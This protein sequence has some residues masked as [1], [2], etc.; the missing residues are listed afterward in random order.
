MDQLRPAGRGRYLT[1]EQYLNPEVIYR[2]NDLLYRI[3][4]G[5]KGLR[6]FRTAHNEEKYAF[7][8]P[9]F[10]SKSTRT[11]HWIAL[12][13]DMWN[14]QENTVYSD[15]TTPTQHLKDLASKL[16]EA[17]DTDKAKATWGKYLED[18][19]SV[20][21]R[22]ERVDALNRIVDNPNSDIDEAGHRA[23]LWAYSGY[24]QHVHKNLEGIL[25]RHLEGLS[26]SSGSQKMHPY[27]VGKLVRADDR[28]ETTF[29]WLKVE[30]DEQ[31]GTL[32]KWESLHRPELSRDSEDGVKGPATGSNV[33]EPTW[34]IARLFLNHLVMRP[35]SFGERLPKNPHVLVLGLF[36]E[37]IENVGY[38]G[39]KAT[40]SLLFEDADQRGAWLEQQLTPLH[41]VSAD[42][43][44]AITESA[45]ILAVADP[46][47]PPYDLLEH[48]LK[49]IRFVQDW[50][51][52]VVFRNGSF[53]YGFRRIRPSGGSNMWEWKR[54]EKR[55]DFCG[56]EQCEESEAI[57]GDPMG[58]RYIWWTAS[59]ANLWSKVFIPGLRVKE[60]A[61]FGACA[62]RFEFQKAARLPGSD[63][64]HA[65]PLR[66][67]YLRQQ[68][69]VMRR[70]V[71]VV[72]ARRNALR[73]AAVSI[74]A[75]N[76]SHNI[77]SHVLAAVRGDK[78]AS[79]EDCHR[80]TEHLQRRMDFIAE[81][82]TVE[83]LSASDNLLF[84][85][86]LG[87]PTRVDGGAA[88]DDTRGLNGQR[89]LLRHITGV[90][91]PHTGEPV[92]AIIDV[93]TD[94][95]GGVSEAK[96][97]FNS[98][99][100][101]WQA[102]YV[103]LE[104]I[105]RNVAKHGRK[106]E[107]A[108]RNPIDVRLKVL[109][110]HDSLFELRIWDTCGHA[111]ETTG[112]A[113]SPVVDYLS[114]TLNQPIFLDADNSVNTADWGMKEMYISAAFLRGIA[115]SDLEA[116]LTLGQE[117][118]IEPC[119][120]DDAGRMGSEVSSGKENLGFRIWL[121][122]AMSVAVFVDD[123][124]KFKIGE[125]LKKNG[126]RLF[127]V[128]EAN[129]DMARI[130]HRFGV[131]LSDTKVE[132]RRRPQLPVGL[133][134]V[135]SGGDACSYLKFIEEDNGPGLTQHVKEQVLRK[136]LDRFAGGNGEHELW[137][138]DAK[139]PLAGFCGKPLSL[140]KRGGFKEAM[141]FDWHGSGV[142]E[143][144]AGGTWAEEFGILGTLSPTQVI[145]E[146]R[147]YESYRSAFPQTGLFG[148]ELG[149]SPK[150]AAGKTPCAEP[151][152]AQKAAILEL[153]LRC[154]ALTPVLI[155]DE[156]F[157]RI[158]EQGP[159]GPIAGGAIPDPWRNHL[160]NFTMGKIWKRMQIIVP[161]AEDG[162]ETCDLESPM[163]ESLKT[164][165]ESIEST[166]GCGAYVV[167][168]Q[169]IFEKLGGEGANFSKFLSDKGAAKD[170]T[171]V[172]C[173]GRGV[174]WQLLGDY[175]GTSYSPRFIAL[176]ALLQCLEKMPSKLHLIRLLEVTRAPTRK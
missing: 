98:G 150:E 103:I 85:E 160:E 34:G 152:T 88:K 91:E 121:P 174:P 129:G 73:N 23:L 36:D 67:A 116:R 32:K 120:M 56:L 40:F 74:M 20:E 28:D 62:I 31:T 55:E 166:L 122:K 42:L 140:L 125:S 113:G 119:A 107:C 8:I 154:A 134:E 57:V 51:S 69:D 77:G 175:N 80:L 128:A 5:E 63:H 17:R 167:V 83:A 19:P 14:F 118:V 142:G 4:L 115:L 155:L 81:L 135:G 123:V 86:V 90:Q 161:F 117:K 60:E 21:D 157:Q 79:I 106:G 10:L 27:V 92:N 46:I 45:A 127:S 82:A 105:I 9:A 110:R 163:L 170:W 50:N 133:L 66:E 124:E 1:V 111:H 130:P 87:T 26:A 65:A 7:V 3:W 104:N 153:E 44:A 2:F 136:R 25:Y 168:H 158:A 149:E 58:P 59:R 54:S 48:F 156:R 108:N 15:G 176:S 164:Y 146:F 165:L 39:L 71:P 89:L 114:A 84:H 78:K 24:H 112:T 38:G 141:V 143:P 101:G 94:E 49:A 159:S 109:D 68:L 138:G 172:V 173:S 52:A 95:G 102:L 41:E 35:R 131:W 11:F 76:M 97:S 30:A 61:T 100:M 75:R 70:L 96:V 132:D 64:V 53:Q 93:V 72:R 148:A 43:A 145:D 169:T 18:L 171:N 12:S 147:F 16:R 162:A 29:D 47:D 126:I 33:L 151:T 139:N 22:Q 137:I 37:Y 13:V 144:S 99:V 6:R